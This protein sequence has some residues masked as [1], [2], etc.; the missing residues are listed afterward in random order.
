MT[1][2]PDWRRRL[3]DFLSLLGGDSTDRQEFVAANS[4]TVARALTGLPGVGGSPSS[5]V[6][7][8]VVVNMSSAHIPA[9][10]KNGARYKNC[11]DLDDETRVG[12]TPPRTSE[13][14]QMVDAALTPLHGKAAAEIYFAAV[15]F[16]GC[17]VGFYGDH[18]MVL[19]DDITKPDSDIVVLDRNSYDLIREP[20]ASQINDAARNLGVT[21]KQAREDEAREHAG[22][23]KD[24]L[25]EI[26][27]IKVL[28]A[29]TPVLRLLTTGAVSEGIL[30]DEDYLEV[31]RPDSF[32]IGDLAEVRLAPADVALDERVRSRSVIGRPPAQ[33]ETVWRTRRRAAEERLVALGVPV[34]VVTTAGRTKG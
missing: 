24:H 29:R 4:G 22:L 21:E 27:A 31:L 33:A 32:G 13:K 11:Y 26:A 10:T 3:D 20:L 1:A 14:R 7:G 6:G 12:E 16:N 28:E 8:C 18:C 15:E 2:F 30:D 19:R 9:L 17:G 34:R 5:G 23:L 25:A